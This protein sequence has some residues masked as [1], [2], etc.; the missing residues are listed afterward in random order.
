LN[1]ESLEA[2]RL[3][4]GDGESALVRFESAEELQTFLLDTS[5]Q[6]WSGLFGQPAWS[7]RWFGPDGRMVLEAPFDVDA[8]VSMGIPDHSDTNVQVAGVDEDDIVETDGNHLYVLS[9]QQLVIADAWLP[10]EMQVLSRVPIDGQPVGQ[11][12][13]GDRLTVISHSYNSWLFAPRVEMIAIDIAQPFYDWTP[14]KTKV[15]VID[16]SDRTAPTIVQSTELDGQYVDSRAIGELV[17]MI[18]SDDLGLPEP[19]ILCES[20]PEDG[21]ASADALMPPVVIDNSCVYETRDQYTQRVAGQLLE[22]GVPQYTSSDGQGQVVETGP[23]G[24][25]TDIYKPVSPDFWSLLSVSVFNMA[26]DEPGSVSSTSVPTSYSANVYA[27]ADSLY[28]TNPEW[29]PDSQEEVTSILKFD[30]VG[31]GTRVDMAAAGQVPGHV[32]NSFSIDEHADDQGNEYLRIATTSGWGDGSQN[33]VFVLQ[34]TGDDLEVVGRTPALA[35]G[36]QI[37]SVRFVD[38]T[39]YVV[40]FRQVDPLFAIDL[41]VPTDPQ[42]QGDLHIPG[43]S[44]Y[45][46]PLRDDFLIGLGRNADPVTGRAEELQISLFDVADLASPKLADRYSFDVPEWAWSEALSDHHAVSYFPDQQVLAIPV[47]N[48]GL[49]WVDRDGDGAT[50]VESYRPRTDLYV[51]HIELPEAGAAQRD[52]K[53]EFLGTVSDDAHVRRSLR[54]EDMLYSISDNSVSVHPILDPKTLVGQLHFGQEGV[55]VP[56]FTADMEAPEVRVAVETPE[57]AAPQVIDVLVGS[58]KWDTNFVNQLDADEAAGDET[59][60]WE[61]FPFADADQIKIRFSEDVYVALSDLTVT[62]QNQPQYGFSGFTYDADTATAVWTLS[63]PVGADS[64]SV[65]LRAINGSVTDLDGNRLD[66]DANGNAGGSFLARYQ[67]LPGDIDQDGRVDGADVALARAHLDAKLGDAA[68][69]LAYDL[70]GNG[71]IDPTDVQILEQRSGTTL[72]GYVAPISGDANGDG[73]FDSADLVE[74]LARGKYRTG[75][76]ASWEDGDW[77][78]DGLFDEGDLIRAFQ[79]GHY[80]D[81]AAAVHAIDA[82]IE[83][84]VD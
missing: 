22:L 60:S 66:G 29:Q 45:L 28:L 19:M 35:R 82:A 58:T 14:P 75:E 56:V 80:V 31:D 71:R 38:E 20:T 67:V 78:R 53:L 6:R 42:V 64:I 36:E 74:V 52:A 62:G 21:G 50:D 69:Q 18:T 70:D 68:Y 83:S 73:R 12:L 37:F 77:N 15:T 11:Y 16:V 3:L 44:N 10:S 34:D 17:Y 1:V 27:S 63:S 24:Q 40:T 41:S 23:I 61:I 79:D 65:R 46:Q 43:F 47:S 57:L 33:R 72:P 5:L 76:F 9:G 7:G 48:N 13:H 25:A 54:I 39:A 8:P 84:L 59:G 55:G 2:R 32:L 4:A 81:N 26:G 51:F 30:I 49:E